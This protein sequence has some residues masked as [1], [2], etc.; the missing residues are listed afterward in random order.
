[1]TIQSAI[2]A[3]GARK[4]V[5]NARLSVLRVQRAW[6]AALLRHWEARFA[7]FLSAEQASLISGHAEVLSRRQRV[8]GTL[9]ERKMITNVRALSIKHVWIRV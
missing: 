7:Q 6:L 9:D 4:Q 3:I 8:K 2:L 5:I 1:V